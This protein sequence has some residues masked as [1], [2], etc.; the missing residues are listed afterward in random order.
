MDTTFFFAGRNFDEIHAEF[1][2]K[3]RHKER[4]KL[5][6][7]GV[8]S[9]M[10]REIGDGQQ[11]FDLIRYYQTPASL[12]GG[13]TGI[14]LRFARMSDDEAWWKA[15]GGVMLYR[16]GVEYILRPYDDITAYLRLSFDGTHVR[17]L[18]NYGPSQ[19]VASRV[20]LRG[21]RLA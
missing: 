1:L 10:V 3:R 15:I 6:T 12:D 13:R 17:R 16:C 21:V 8:R 14:R 4:Q 2:D 18:H 20:C 11:V 5:V 19:V 9:T 7:S